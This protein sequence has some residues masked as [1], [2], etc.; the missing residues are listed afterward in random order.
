MKI[1]FVLGYFVK[2]FDVLL[3][4]DNEMHAFNTLA[5]NNKYRYFI[6]ILEFD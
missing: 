3:W 4:H 2:E 1:L 6:N 5:V